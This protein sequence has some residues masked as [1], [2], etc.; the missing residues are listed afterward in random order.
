MTPA[1]RQKLIAQA[2]EWFRKVII[3]NHLR[4]TQKLVSAREF[5]INP[6]LVTYLATFFGGKPNPESIARALLYPRVLGT[7]ITTSFG[8]NMQS[9]ICNVLKDSFGSMVPGID[10]EFVDAVDGRKK[11]C[12]AK[13]GPNTINKD[14]VKTIH[15]H[16]R[17]ARNL[18]KTNNLKVAV[19]DMVVAIMYGNP[20][21]E[22]GHYK[23]L[24]GEHGYPLLIGADF[25]H[26]LTG[27]QYFY[28]DLLDGLLRS[29]VDAA[30]ENDVASVLEKT[31][32][33]LSGTD[34]VKT[35][36][37]RLAAQP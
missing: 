4:N 15:D 37:I 24:S 36:A 3:P 2:T 6:F 21:Q 27:D 22:N 32:E 7:S 30:V 8:T 1:D 13:L 9:F 23:R 34:T 16:F 31:V 19:D 17:D 26:R 35:L 14:D 12:Q 5:D 29:I 28:A 20:G 33:A 18:G 10:I 11:Y 25:W